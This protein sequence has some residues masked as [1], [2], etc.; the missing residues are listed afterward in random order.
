MTQDRKIKILARLTEMTA[1]LSGYDDDDLIP[2]Q[3]FL[4]LGFDSLFLTQ[5]ATAFQKEF[6]VKVTFRQLFDELPTLDQMAG[7]L[8]GQLP[9]E[10][11]AEVASV[12]QPVSEVAETESSDGDIVLEQSPVDLDSSNVQAVQ[13][14]EFSQP[15]VADNSQVVQISELGILGLEDAQNLAEGES[16]TICLSQ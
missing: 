12:P 11:F 7:H 4:E 8:D 2:T 6:G 14:S 5:L 1:E 16:V 13:F 15:L 10:A 9:T 3:T